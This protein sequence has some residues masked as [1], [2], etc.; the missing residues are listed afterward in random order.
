MKRINCSSANLSRLLPPTVSS[1]RL[2]P[3]PFLSSP[4]ASHTPR[5]LQ[6]HFHL[7]FHNQNNLPLTQHLQ[8]TSGPCL[9]IQHPIFRKPNL[10]S[11]NHTR[12]RTKKHI[13]DPGR[14]C[15]SCNKW[16]TAKNAHLTEATIYHEISLSTPKH[17]P[18]TLSPFTQTARYPTTLHPPRSPISSKISSPFNNNNNNPTNLPK[19][20]TTPLPPPLQ[21][22]SHS[23]PIPSPPSIKEIKSPI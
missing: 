14:N 19:K 3:Y 11:P 23:T 22:I 1:Y 4:L 18:I 21:H 5:E 9:T 10:S 20:S 2:S 12:K 13:L 17:T 15:L 6:Y 7:A 8:T 16:R